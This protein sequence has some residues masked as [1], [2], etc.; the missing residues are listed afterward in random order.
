MIF[1]IFFFSLVWSDNILE[2]FYSCHTKSCSSYTCYGECPCEK[3]SVSVIWYTLSM[4][5]YKDFFSVPDFDFF[6]FIIPDYHEFKF[7]TKLWYI[8][9]PFALINLLWQLTYV[10]NYFLI[11]WIS[12]RNLWI[13]HSL[14]NV[15]KFILQNLMRSTVFW[16]CLLYWDI[17]NI[18]K[19]SMLRSQGQYV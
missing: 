16:T 7:T 19:F 10:E 12:F 3:L 6:R 15:S 4:N 11:N 18:V 5:I 13:K 1:L 2:L 9:C 8:T 14:W 17:N